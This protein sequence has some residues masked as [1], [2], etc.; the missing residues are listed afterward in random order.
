MVLLIDTNIIIDFIASREPFSEVATE[1]IRKCLTNKV[2]GY[3]AA[4]SITNTFYILRKHFSVNERKE[5]LS[6]LCKIL[7]VV[8]LDGLSVANSLANRTFDDLEDCLQVACAK[9][10]GAEYIVT[11]NINDFVHSQ[12]PAVLPEY[13]LEQLD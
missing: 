12:I 13:I 9:T 8:D 5:I 10:I 3:V 2:T 11:R 7:K 6:E 1:L 4:H